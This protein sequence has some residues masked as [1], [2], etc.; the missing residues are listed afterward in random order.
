MS[1]IRVLVV[2]DHTIVREGIRSLL[3]R[4]KDIEVVGEASDGSQAIAQAAALRPDVVLMDI[5]MPRIDGLQ[6]TQSIHQSFPNVRILVLTQYENKEYV[7]PLL[8]A[9]ASGYLAKLT[10]A[11]DLIDAIRAVYTEGA[12]LPPGIAREVVSG[13]SQGE[14]AAPQPLLSEREK[15]VVRLIASGASSREIAERLHISVRTVDTHRANIMERFGVH[16]SAELI[17]SAIREGIIN[18]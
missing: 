2:D 7:F 10:R 13:V 15:E 8:R 17:V 16:S 9:G 12:Y 3:A 4:R 5:A 18:V 14:G 11:S 1:K 6:A